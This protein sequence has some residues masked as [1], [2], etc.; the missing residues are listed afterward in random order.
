VATLRIALVQ[1]ASSGRDVAANLDRGL[2]A[3]R[4]AADRGADLALFPEMW[5]VGYAAG[6]D[7]AL[8]EPI[9]GGFVSAFRTLARERSIAIG[10]TWLEAVASAK[11][12]NGIAL[13]DAHG[14]IVL[15][16]A[17]VHLCPWGPPD[18]ECSAGDG[19]PVATL[20]TRAGPVAVGAMICFDREFPESAKL[21]ALGGAE[22]VLV[23]NACALAEDPEIGD[24]RLAQLRG[25]AFEN[26]VAIAV[27][28]YAAPQH[29]GRSCVFLPDGATLALAGPGEE[30]VLADLD[31]DRLRAFRAREIGRSEARRPELYAAISR[32][33]AARPAPRSRASP[34]R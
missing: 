16:T 10:V 24:V 31:L 18:A 5:S 12:R 32:P 1:L 28:N 26:L 6:F 3:C 19:F 22:L 4:E 21:L 13:I 34:P 7:P 14:E 2:A 17:K 25:R 11:P 20:A 23:P 8:A 9:D 33:A 27:A 29:D 30:I 15:H